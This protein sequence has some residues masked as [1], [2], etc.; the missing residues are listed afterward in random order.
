M[1][2]NIKRDAPTNVSQPGKFYI[3]GVYS[4]YTLERHPDDPDHKCI[5]AG[6]YQ[7]TLRPTYNG[8]LWTPYPDRVLPHIEN[9]PGRSGIEMHAG[10]KVQDSEG[11]VMHGYERPD[12]D[13]IGVSRNCVKDLIDKMRADGGPY[14]ILVE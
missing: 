5:P 9:V 14:T 7:V 3:D 12:P 8:R 4:N 6:T 1:N 10:N 11:C 13:H 2:L